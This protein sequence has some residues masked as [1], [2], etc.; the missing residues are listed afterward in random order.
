[1][2]SSQAVRVDDISESN[3]SDKTIKQ[4]LTTYINTAGPTDVVV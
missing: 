4:V 2:A 3:R 1:M